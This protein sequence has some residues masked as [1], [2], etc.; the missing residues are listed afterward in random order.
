MI[1]NRELREYLEVQIIPRY[2][3]ND[4]GHGVEH[5][6]YVIDRSLRFAAAAGKDLNMA[7]VIAAYHDV[8]HSIDAKNHEK[9]SAQILLEDLKLKKFFSDSQ[10]KIMAEAV[11]DHRSSLEYEPRSIYG[12]IV[13]S[14]DR[15]TIVE[16]VFERTYEYRKK[17]YSNFS[18]KQIIDGS[19]RHVVEKFGREGYA[20]NKMYFKD[21]HYEEF[22]QTLRKLIENREEFDKQF[23]ITNKLEKEFIKREIE[24]F[25]PLVRQEKFDKEQMLKFIETND[26]ILTRDNIFGHFTASAFVVNEDFDKTLLVKHNRLGGYIFPGGHADGEY[27]LLSVAIREVLEETGLDVVPYGKALYSICSVPVKAHIRNGFYVCSHNHYDLLYLCVAKNEDMDKIRTLE[28][29]NSD[30]KWVDLEDCYNEE[31]VDW[32]RPIN[33]KMVGKIKR[34]KR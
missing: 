12:K 3:A 5:A 21:E 19:Y 6:K 14:A 10:I 25:F 22:L 16:S 20:N 26:D 30:V 29:E 32:V 31:V 1:I 8:G 18:L 27:D 23:I 7:Y 34:L 11:E 24:E 13:S 4:K 9:I 17:H 33:E 15:N 2:N 28:S